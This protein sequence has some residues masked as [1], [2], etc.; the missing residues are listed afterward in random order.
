[1]LSEGLEF[2]HLQNVR[3][4]L[5]S[6]CREPPS[7]CYYPG[8]LHSATVPV[9]GNRGLTASRLQSGVLARTAFTEDLNVGA[10]RLS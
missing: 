3:P 7:R 6:F 10:R 9:T 4:G 8:C 2:T 1:M 5:C